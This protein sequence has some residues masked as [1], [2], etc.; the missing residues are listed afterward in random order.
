MC[1]RVAGRLVEGGL[2]RVLQGGWHPL[3]PHRSAGTLALTTAAAMGLPAAS[4][5]LMTQASGVPQGLWLPP[6]QSPTASA[7]NTLLKPKTLQTPTRS[8]RKQS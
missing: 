6:S 1:G 5:A 8:R 3:N 7:L 2:G 4:P